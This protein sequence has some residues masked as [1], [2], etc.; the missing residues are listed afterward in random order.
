[1]Q[2]AGLS[3]LGW[4]IVTFKMNSKKTQHGVYQSRFTLL[5]LMQANFP[6]LQTE[7]KRSLRTKDRAGAKHRLAILQVNFHTA[8]TYV[9]DHIHTITPGQA[10]QIIN[11]A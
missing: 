6:S 10:Q 7:Y 5:L 3:Q 2:K 9:S 1:M 11:K 4:F 8:I